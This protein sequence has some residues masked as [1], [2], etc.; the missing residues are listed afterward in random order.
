MIYRFGRSVGFKL[1]Y[2][3]TIIKAIII[4]GFPLIL[5][6]AFLT[7]HSQ[8]DAL[9]LDKLSS[10]NEV[11]AFGAGLRVLSA[12]IFLPAVFT[13][14][15]GPPVT[16]AIVIQDFDKIS[17]TV[18]RSLRLLLLSALFI[19]ITLS[20]SSTAV[21]NI[22]FGSNKYSDA[23]PLA[24]IFGWTFIPISFGSFI[25]DIAIAE[26]KF[27]VPA[28]YTSVL[29]VI[30]I[31]CDLILIPHYGALGAVIAKCIAVTIGSIILLIISE[32]LHVLVRKRI[33]SFFA[34]LGAIAFFTL[35]IFYALS[36]FHLHPF[37]LFSIASATFFLSA[38]FLFKIITL[39]EIW[40]FIS[41]FL[42]IKNQK[43][44]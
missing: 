8:A 29:M 43:E 22:L 7:I 35:G 27:W 9:L 38:I 24:V 19:A 25:T 33:I 26:G 31:G 4:E 10:A 2:N 42:A 40:M 14:V 21:V 39:H 34:Q 17:S 28:L 13:A 5:S 1:H 12:V 11:S 30:S 32:K 6:T 41:S 37:F 44:I 15:I 16:Q 36:F 18:D 23:A 20:L 3:F